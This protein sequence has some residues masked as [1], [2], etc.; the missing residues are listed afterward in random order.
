MEKKERKKNKWRML[1]NK[2]TF[3]CSFHA[4][5]S[6]RYSS[7]I[8]LKWTSDNAG[9]MHCIKE[10]NARYHL[11]GSPY[12][13]FFFLSLLF[14]EANIYGLTTENYR[15]YAISSFIANISF[16]RLMQMNLSEFSYFEQINEIWLKQRLS[17]NGIL[18]GF[19]SF[20]NLSKKISLKSSVSI[21]S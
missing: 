16:Q 14:L 12:I 9:Q 21:I 8:L 17:I 18:K 4:I 20:D 10:E 7:G 19:F 13:L 3:C 5:F 15:C 1:N 2:E 11:V 6:F